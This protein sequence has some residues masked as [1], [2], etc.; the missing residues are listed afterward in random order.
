MNA[1]DFSLPEVTDIEIAMD[2]RTVAGAYSVMLGNLVVYYNGRTSSV[3]KPE[4]NVHETAIQMLQD[5]V[6][7]NY[8]E[9][10]RV[11][12]ELPE[13][14]RQA[15]AAYVNSFDDDEPIRELLN[16]FGQSDSGSHVHTQV[17]WLCINALQPIV[18]CWKTIC[19][20]DAAQQI[21]A[22]LQRWLKDRS[23]LINWEA[24]RQPLVA[25]R[26]GI[27]I[28]DCD[29]C[30]VEPI[31][32]ALAHCADYLQTAHTDSAVK[33]ILEA[34]GAHAEGCWPA[35]EERPYEQWFIEVA[36]PKAYQCQEVG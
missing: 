28:E 6:R 13:P 36:L 32:N 19:D 10:N 34:W 22:E 11:P 7:Q 31:A 9:I 1:S 20:D 3:S 24:A 2:G 27:K 8:I 5:L 18:P 17:C 12:S 15:A 16:A 30:R 33:V 35:D 14:I 23:Y 21:L 29:A 26:G 25:R 4:S